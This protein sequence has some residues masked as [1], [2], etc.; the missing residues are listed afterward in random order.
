MNKTQGVFKRIEKKYLLTEVQYQTLRRRIASRM[1]TDAYSHST[2]RNIYFDTPN[3]LLVRRSM[4]K[5]VYKEKLRLRC[6]DLPKED[7]TAFIEIKKKYDQVVYKR[8]IKMSYA[9]AIDYLCNG[10]RP[11]KDSQI[12]REIDWFQHLYTGISPA[13]VISYDRFAVF[14]KEN[15][16]FRLTLDS[17]IL[18]RDYD[19]DLTRGVYGNSLLKSGEHLMEIKIPDAMPLWMCHELEYAGIYPASYSKYG[20][21]YKNLLSGNRERQVSYSA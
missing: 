6:Y 13:M 19:L 16:D 7:S 3:Y 20:N 8:R 12:L 9:Q 2:I 14:E 15:P 4:D 11:P 1:G 18:W 17:N 5:P 10:D 21:A